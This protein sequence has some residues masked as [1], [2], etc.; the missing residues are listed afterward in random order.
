MKCLF[1]EKCVAFL[2]IFA[3]GAMQK[4]EDYLT[5]TAFIE[6]GTTMNRNR[7]SFFCQWTENDLW[8][9][10][11]IC[12][13]QQ[14]YMKSLNSPLKKVYHENN[15]WLWN[16]Y[17]LDGTVRNSYSVLYSFASLSRSTKSNFFMWVG[18][19]YHRLKKWIFR[20]NQTSLYI[21]VFHFQLNRY[22]ISTN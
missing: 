8:L 5:A 11:F 12:P 10:L 17:N 19:Y 15:V 18:G 1:F 7:N 14:Y 22:A 9:K 13:T 21:M 2:F 16:I 3:I 6:H 4:I 20:Y